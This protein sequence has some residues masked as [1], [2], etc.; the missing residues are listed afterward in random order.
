MQV[1]EINRVQVEEK[2]VQ[3]ETK[4]RVQIDGRIE[5]RLKR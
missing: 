5:I 4:D 2:R 1:E 3:D